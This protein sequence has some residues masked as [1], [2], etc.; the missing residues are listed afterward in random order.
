MEAEISKE[1]SAILERKREKETDRGDER[2]EERDRRTGTTT[3]RRISV[4]KNADEAEVKESRTRP[5]SQA[6]VSSPRPPNGYLRS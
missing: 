1:T 5:K 6:G 2:K 3:R 4:L